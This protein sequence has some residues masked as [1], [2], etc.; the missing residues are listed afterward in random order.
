MIMKRRKI[1]TLSAIGIAAQLICAA[2]MTYTGTVVLSVCKG[3]DDLVIIGVLAIAYPFWVAIEAAINTAEAFSEKDIK[4]ITTI[5][6][7]ITRTIY[8]ASMVVLTIYYVWGNGI[9]CPSDILLVLACL[10][11]AVAMCVE[12][13]IHCVRRLKER[14]QNDDHVYEYNGHL[15]F[16]MGRTARVF[17]KDTLE[18]VPADLW[19]RDNGGWEKILAMSEVYLFTKEK[20]LDKIKQ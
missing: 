19:A 11:P 6:R 9:T 5:I 17:D 3:K 8:A 1:S 10:L 16:F 18:E 4:N 2:L 12:L 13:I 15:Y 20:M 14:L 7:F